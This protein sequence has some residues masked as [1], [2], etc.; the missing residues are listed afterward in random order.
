MPIIVIVFVAITYLYL[1]LYLKDSKTDFEFKHKCCAFYVPTLESWSINSH[2]TS[3]TCTEHGG[4][5]HVVITAETYQL[6]YIKKKNY[7]PTLFFFG[8]VTRNTEFFFLG[9]NTNY[10]TNSIL[11][12]WFHCSILEIHHLQTPQSH[13]FITKWAEIWSVGPF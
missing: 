11:T 12:I 8:P 10:R 13:I 7:L 1:Y 5:R 2:N 9:L 3:E 6:L 4:S